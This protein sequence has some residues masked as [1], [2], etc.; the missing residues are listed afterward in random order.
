MNVSHDANW[1][2][3]EDVCAIAALLTP[4]LVAR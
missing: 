2:T 4:A 3:L 1:F